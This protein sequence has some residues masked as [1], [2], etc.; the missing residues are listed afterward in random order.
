VT[1]EAAVWMIGEHHR[2]KRFDRGWAAELFKGGKYW[3]E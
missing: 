1:P 2:L 3:G